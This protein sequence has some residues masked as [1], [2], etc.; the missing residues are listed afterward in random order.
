[1]SEHNK[2]NE[3]PKKEELFVVELD[4]RLEF[5]A[6]IIDSDLQADLNTGCNY[7]CVNKGCPPEPN[8]GCNNWTNCTSPDNTNCMNGSGC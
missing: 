1:M 7:N 2:P 4:E 3:A 5:G 8:N 6:A